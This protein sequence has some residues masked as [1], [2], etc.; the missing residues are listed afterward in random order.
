MSEHTVSAENLTRLRNSFAHVARELLQQD[1][2]PPRAVTTPVL[3]FSTMTESDWRAAVRLWREHADAI[4]AGVP[5]RACPACDSTASRAIFTSYDAHRFHECDGCGCWFTPKWIDWSV[6]ETLFERN[7]AARDLAARMM[8]AR[9]RTEQRDADMG[10]IGRY[11][12]DVLPLLPVTGRRRH[13]LDAGCGVGHSL[14]AGRARGLNVQGVEVDTAAIALAR[15]D[16]L[17][18]VNPGETLPAGPYHLL[19]FWETLEHIADPKAA[20]QQYLPFLDDDG[21]VA[22][23]VPNLNAL[24]TRALRE[25][26]SWVHGG[27]NTPGH[28]NLFHAPALQALLSR[29]GLTLLDAQGEFSADAENLV[30]SLMGI[31]RGAFDVLEGRP[32]T[33]TIPAVMADLLR[34]VWPGVALLE[35]LSLA[36]PIL[37]AVACKQGRERR[38]EAAVVARRQ[39]RRDQLAAAAAALIAMEPDWKAIAGHLDGEVKRQ[40]TVMTLLQEGVDLRDRLLEQERERYAR[41][42]NGRVRRVIQMAGGAARRLGLRP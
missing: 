24:E 42:V 38:F 16:G 13:Y 14:R 39:K 20:L 23:T 10:R 29:A 11:L 17:P 2:E 19:S 22:I 41:T 8:A 15:A 30:V 31:T 36:S 37:Y 25:S 9:D 32:P 7:P 33:R 40:A 35:E 18:V 4:L 1:G 28:V 6:F 21:L 5:D 12:D 3:P 34:Q 27:Y 26:C